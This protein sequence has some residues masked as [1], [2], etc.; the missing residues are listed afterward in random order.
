MPVVRRL[1]LA[2]ILA[3]ATAIAGCVGD[4]SPSPSPAPSVARPSVA[5]P[6]IPAAATCDA[7][8]LAGA[9][10]AAAIED[11]GPGATLC[12]SGTF[13]VP[14][15][16]RPLDGQA[17]VGPATLVGAE[18]NDTGF[19]VGDARD[20]GFRGLEMSG[21]GLR[22]I[23]CGIGTVVVDSF[24]HHNGRNGVGCGLGGEGG[25]LI[26]RS[27]I[28]FNGSEEHLGG[29]SSGM[30][31]ARGDGIVVRDSHVHDNLGIGIWC[32]VQCGD[33]TVVG[34]LI[35]R[36]SRKG[37]HYEKSGESD[38]VV[39]YVGHALIE[40]NVVVGNGWEGREHAADGGIVCV[41]CKNVTIRDNTT[42]DNHRAGIVIKQDGR[43]A[44]PKHGWT[45]ENVVVGTN[46][47]ADGVDGCDLPG[48]A[49]A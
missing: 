20:V 10:L 9:D 11:G 6:S 22:A 36:N 21:F 19:D 2:A 35:E 40:G 26:E 28:A 23:E 39:A 42:E 24:L 38:E 41:S 44:G 48:V 7:R 37:V 1:P 43:V 34:N 30:K 27:E 49:C 47:V 14:D 25:V 3:L 8:V 12:L 13:S 15:P 16:L 32:D 45:V 31:F 46:A 4:R 29:G 17:F 33:L 5:G 18:D